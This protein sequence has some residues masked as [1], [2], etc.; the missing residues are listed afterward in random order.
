M[1]LTLWIVF[2]KEN[3]DDKKLQ[4]QIEDELKKF[5]KDARLQDASKNI[6][7]CLKYRHLLNVW[8]PDITSE[9]KLTKTIIEALKKGKIFTI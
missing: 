1:N 2:S 7:E 9:L 3:I 4:D 8:N 6:Q 5:I